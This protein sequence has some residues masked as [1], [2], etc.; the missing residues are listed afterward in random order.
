M[1]KILYVICA[2]NGGCNYYRDTI[3]FLK[4]KHK[5]DVKVYKKKLSEMVNDHDVIIIGH[6]VTNWGDGKRPEIEN[7]TD[8]PLYIILNKEY[9]RLGEKLEWIKELKPIKCFTVHHDSEL[10]SKKTKIPFVRISWSADHKVFKN[11][12]EPYRN[13]L[14]FSGVVRLGQ[15][16]NIRQKIHDLLCRL[17][18]PR[19]KFNVIGRGDKNIKGA[20]SENIDYAKELARSKI[21][22]VTTGPADLVGTRYFEIMAGNRCLILCNRMPKEVYG[23]IAIDGF[24]CVMF[25]DE[26]DFIQKY[27]FFIAN[28]DKRMEIVHRAYKYFMDNHTWDHHIKRL[29]DNLRKK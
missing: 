10:Y 5:V 24:N 18:L 9:A 19:V 4:K 3:D 15:K 20:R 25:D 23:N 16:N 13:D 1:L 21:G 27:R 11:Y 12:K 2:F 26:H 14:F 22:F 29:S 17:K 28:E 7:D 8:V 6:S